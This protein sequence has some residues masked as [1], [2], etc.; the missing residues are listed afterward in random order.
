MSSGV[1]RFSLTPHTLLHTIILYPRILHLPLLVCEMDEEKTTGET[2]VSEGQADSKAEADQE[3]PSGSP[4]EQAVQQ[5]E[6]EEPKKEEPEQSDAPEEAKQKEQVDAQAPEAEQQ[7]PEAESG[8][9]GQGAAAAA[10]SSEE[11]PPKKS[12]NKKQKKVQL[13]VV[14]LEGKD[15]DLEENVSRII[16]LASYQVGVEVIV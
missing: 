13:K 16:R 9:E 2:R 7:Q 8:Q 12:S 4:E 1:V 5:D 11:V 10:A 15:L 6:Q 3:Q 14:L